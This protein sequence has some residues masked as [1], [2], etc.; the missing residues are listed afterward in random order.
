VSV[1]ARW[2]CRRL[3]CASAEGLPDP[4]HIRI[5]KA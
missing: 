2:D 3:A 4:F 5:G 1:M